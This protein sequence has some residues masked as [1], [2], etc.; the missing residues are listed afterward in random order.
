MVLGSGPAK[1]AK[2]R[3][4]WGHEVGYGLAFLWW[5]AAQAPTAALAVG[6][7]ASEL[8]EQQAKLW[9]GTSH[10]DSSCVRAQPPRAARTHWAVHPCR[11]GRLGPVPPEPR[12]SFCAGSPFGCYPDR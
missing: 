4:D 8:R 3:E 5:C 1:A 2:A 12:N 10:T 6:L 7:A 9:P 11:R